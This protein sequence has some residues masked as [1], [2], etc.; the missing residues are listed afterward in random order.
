MTPKPHA[1]KFHRA[2]PTV[3]REALIEAT[4]ECLRKHGHDGVS[5]RRIAAEAGVSAGLITHHFPSISALVAAAYETLAMRLLSSIQQHAIELDAG[6]RERLRRFFEA[7][8]APALLEPGLFSTWLVFWSMIAHDAAVRA[9]QDRTYVAYRDALE[10]LLGQLRASKGVPAFK[11]R[12]AGIALAAL[13]DGLWIE[14]SLNAEAF[15]PAE[16]VALCEDWVHALC[17]GALP[18]LLVQ[19]PEG[20]AR[21]AAS[22]VGPE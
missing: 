2:T 14:A 9:V 17:Y 5:A 11:L 10:S 12:P 22:S 21:R 4:L 15:R 20:R 16:A 7:S 18:S 1:P 19:R 6:P 13:L 3:R 8:F